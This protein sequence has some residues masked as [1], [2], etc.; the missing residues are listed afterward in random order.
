MTKA[1]EAYNQIVDR[2]I[3]M[4]EQGTSPWQNPV[5]TKA[6]GLPLRATGEPYQGMNILACWMGA[7]E[8]G[9]TGQQWFTFKQMAGLGGR[10]VEGSK[11][12]GTPVFYYGS[13]AKEQADGSQAFIPYS[14]VY[15]VWN[16][17]QIEGLPERYVLSNELLDNP[18]VEP[19]EDFFSAT[20]SVVST[21][22]EGRCY[23][24]PSQD[25]IVM[26][27]IGRFRSVAS[28]YGTMAHEHVHWTG[29]KHRLDRTLTTSKKLNEYAFEELV[30]ELGSAFLMQDLG[31]V[32]V[33]TESHAAYIESWLRGLQN[34]RGMLRKAASQASKAVGYLKDAVAA[35]RE[36]LAA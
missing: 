4:L 22:D 26:P 2:I 10:L 34:D 12:K 29:A 18:P 25:R 24:V 30:A 31:A 36:V 35:D 33:E 8:H 11:G 9:W 27:P 13:V 17:D 7:M 19:L 23:Y 16:S 14:K 21:V 32:P 5:V 1:A 28:Y 20:G 3:N 15:T 6:G